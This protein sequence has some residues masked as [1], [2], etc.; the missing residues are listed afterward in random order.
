MTF[1]QLACNNVLRNKRTYAAYF[2]SSSFSAM[3]FFVYGMFIYHPEIEHAPLRELVVGGMQVAEFITYVFSFFFVLYSVGAFLKSRKREFGI[4]L[5]H[6]MSQGQLNKMVF[7]ENMMI[8]LASI[9]TGIGSGLVCSKLI[10]LVGSSILSMPQLSFYLPWKAMFMTASAFV[11]LFLVISMCTTF[12]VRGSKLID[13]LQGSVKPKKEPKASLLLS[14]LSAGLIGT[15]YYLSLT[16]TAETIGARLIPVVFMVVVGTYFFYTQLSVYAIRLLKRQRTFFWHRTNLITLS[17]LGYR[18]KDNARMFFLVTIVSTVAFCAVG[19]L[20]SSASLERQVRD[21]TPF[22]LNYVALSNK[23]HLSTL[24]GEIE[25]GLK[26]DNIS[27]TKVTATV[28]YQTSQQTE[29]R[30][31]LVKQ[32]DFNRLAQ[33]LGYKQVNLAT[34]EA[35]FI[36]ESPYSMADY[37]NLK[38][39]VTF[40]ESHMTVYADG[41]V[42][43]SVFPV[44]AIG[45]NALVVSDEVFDAI[46]PSPNED[47]FIGYNVVDWKK[48]EKLGDYLAR[49]QAN[50][51]LKEYFSAFASELKLM[52]QT[53]GAMLFIGVLVG[54]VFFIAAGSFLYF[55]LYTDLEHDQRQYEAISKIG[56]TDKELNQIVTRQLVLLFFVPIMTAIV[57]SGFAFAALQSVI[58]YP[59]A[60]HTIS[61][62]A[63][64]LFVQVLYF[65]LI[66]SR[67][68]RHVRAV[69][70]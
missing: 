67:Y 30:V 43:R 28:K 4:L 5:M 61:V 37:D 62:L 31:G 41:R 33:V 3:V 64:F 32:S 9:M 20:A 21:R 51:E 24:P 58:Y 7:L 34:T 16:T 11:A 8:G 50:P 49:K 52:Q 22:T 18:I 12:F 17:V 23:M 53:S 54:A 14:L 69:A 35:R 66:R 36:P 70:S 40:Q 59:I 10:L 2:L 55:R 63:S 68:L 26:N 44:F 60:I 48:T 47:T 29:N 6:G 57:H 25:Q 65:L 45:F 1:W 38:R 39:E 13:L 27:Y 15:G 46:G 56:L 19:T 42:D